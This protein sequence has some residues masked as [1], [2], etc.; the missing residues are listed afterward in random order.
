E[1]RVRFRG[2]GRWLRPGGV[3]SFVDTRAPEDGESG[4]Y[5]DE[6]ETLRDP[7][8]RR[9]YTQREWIAFC[10]Q[11]GLRIEKTE[12]V[13]KAHDFEAWLERGGE[14]A[15]TQQRVR[16]RSSTLQHRQCVISRS[17]STTPR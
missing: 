6:V 7:T 9:I 2:V 13:R 3:F 8:H 4:T 17:S 11:G 14:D 5:Q 1:G 16:S 10:E 12:V 15:A